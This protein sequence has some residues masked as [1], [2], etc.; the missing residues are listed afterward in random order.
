MVAG[1]KRRTD[2]W[3]RVSNLREERTALNGRRRRLPQRFENGRRQI[4]QAR[5]STD[6]P[7]DKTIPGKFKEQGHVDGSVVKE[8]TVGQFA[9][10]AEGFA[11]IGGDGDQRVVIQPLFPQII[12]QLAYRRIHVGDT[13]IVRS[14]RKSAAERFGWIVGVVR[15]PQVEP[16]E[17]R[18]ALLLP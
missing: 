2:S 6:T 12:K 8:N 18:T 5:S 17:K 14:L 4:H 16:Q 11:V 7:A 1:G 3:V 15:V 9:V 10:V 13:P